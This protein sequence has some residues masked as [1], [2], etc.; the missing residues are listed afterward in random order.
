VVV[1]GGLAGFLT[2]VSVG[3]FGEFSTWPTT[4]AFLHALTE[5]REALGYV[6]K[7]LFGWY[8]FAVAAVMAAMIAL[9]LR[10]L[11]RAPRPSGRRVALDTLL[12]SPVSSASAS[13]DATRA[14]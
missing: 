4:F 14:S 10:A 1:L 9:W 12:S 2:V 3:F 6:L 8:G 7:P 11:E 13:S 5:P